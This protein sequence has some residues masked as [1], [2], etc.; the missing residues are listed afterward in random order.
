MG[1]VFH[2]LGQFRSVRSCP[3]AIMKMFVSEFAP[4]KIPLIHLLSIASFNV[5]FSD[6]LLT[7]ED[8]FKLVKNVHRCE[9]VCVRVCIVLNVPYIILGYNGLVMSERALV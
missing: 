5:K 8:K 2:S 9:S 4:I 3:F 7:N 6:Y 1:L